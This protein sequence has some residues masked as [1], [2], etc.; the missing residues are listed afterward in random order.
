MLQKRSK[1]EKLTPFRGWEAPQK[2]RRRHFCRAASHFAYN[3]PSILHRSGIPASNLQRIKQT[4]IVV[5]D[6]VIINS[7][8]VAI[9]S[10][11]ASF[12]LSTPLRLMN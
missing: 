5:N 9:L 8:V 7:K 1:K 2:P 10:A 11:T 6:L 4:S 3:G 12:D